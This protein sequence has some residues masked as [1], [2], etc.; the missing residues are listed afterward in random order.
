MNDKSAAVKISTE[1]IKLDSF[2]KLANAAQTGGEAKHYILEGLVLV[3]G[4]KCLMRGKKLRSGTKVEI[5]SMGKI[6][7]V[8]G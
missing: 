6:F 7:E 3:D 5:P 2:L 1:Y 8:S 4:E